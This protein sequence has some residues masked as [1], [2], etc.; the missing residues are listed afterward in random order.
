MI[1][2][3]TTFNEGLSIKKEWS[4]E[5]K[6]PA[7]WILK[8]DKLE[9]VP[10]DFP[11]ERTHREIYHVDPCE[12]ASR[13][14]EAL[15]VLSIEAEYDCERAKAKCRTLDFVSFRIRLYAGGEN[16]QPVVVEVQRRRG[17]S[18]SFMQSCR[19]ILDAAEGVQ[20][21][22]T[23][24]KR[25]PPSLVEGPIGGMKCLQGKAPPS[26]STF[27]APFEVVLQLLSSQKRDAN[28]L[29]MEKLSFLTDPLKTHPVTA[30]RV[31][32]IVALGDASYSVREDTLEILQRDVFAS[33][34]DPDESES[35]KNY[36]EQL[37]RLALVVLSNSLSMTGKEGSLAKAIMEQRWFGECL[38]PVLLDEIKSASERPH[39]AH[40][41]A[42]SISCLVESSDLARKLLH[43]SG[44]VRLLEEA[45]KIGEAR[46]ELLA[47]ETKRCLATL[48][49]TA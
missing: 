19:A 14:S 15:R 10:I 6:V 36:S 7:S 2:P 28:V 46:H 43:D 38:L 47:N 39:C 49:Y 22:L 17:S 34:F 31:C 8:T 33:E 9:P 13:I 29:G 24:N 26:T 44:C 12:V 20:V 40:E 35:G 27:V 3:L 30:L 42:C 45:Y 4:G 21:C 41:A 25:G 48:N 11:L 23:T 1:R 18:F 5:V 32:R 16:N 37:R